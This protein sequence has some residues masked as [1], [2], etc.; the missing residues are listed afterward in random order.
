MKITTKNLMQTFP[1]L[2]RREAYHIMKLCNGGRDAQDSLEGLEQ[3]AAA[4][5]RR[6]S[7]CYNR[8]TNTDIVLHA[9]NSLICGHGVDSAPY[10]ENAVRHGEFISFVNMGDTYSATVLFN[11]ETNQFEISDW[12]SLYETSP[13]CQRIYAENND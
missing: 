10:Y 1:K 3:A 6:V 4:A 2:N 12:G 8:P 11:P 7:E 5:Q 9:I 13:E